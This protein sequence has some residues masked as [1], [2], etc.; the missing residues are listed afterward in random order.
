MSAL[1]MDAPGGTDVFAAQPLAIVRRARKMLLRVIL[2]TD[3]TRHLVVVEGLADRARSG[4]AYRPAVEDDVDELGGALVH[5]ADLAGSAR[6]LPDALEWTNRLVTEFRAQAL[7]EAA[8]GIPVT[9]FMT[10]LTDGVKVARLQAAFIAGIVLPL[11]RAAASRF[12][13]LDEPLANLHA[14]LQ[15]FEAARGG[16]AASAASTATAPG[17]AAG[18]AAGAGAIG[19]GSGDG[20]GDGGQGGGDRVGEVRPGSSHA[21]LRL[22]DEPTAGAPAAQPLAPR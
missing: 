22:A 3:M 4:A 12:S 7:Q 14:T 5:C 2:A 9:A 16:G 13:G 1:V 10:G 18:A 8:R 17:A 15:Y 20:S 21:L 19:S 11:W 6:S